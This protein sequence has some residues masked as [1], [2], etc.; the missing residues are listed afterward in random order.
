MASRAQL[1]PSALRRKLQSM[2]PVAMR[3]AA[4][5]SESS[6]ASMCSETLDADEFSEVLTAALSVA[7]VLARSRW[8]TGFQLARACTRMESTYSE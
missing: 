4:Q 3:P 1:E 5:G 2:L 8:R 7:G 6:A